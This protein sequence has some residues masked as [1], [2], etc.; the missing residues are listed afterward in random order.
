MNMIKEIQ[1]S[2]NRFEELVY[3]R[4]FLSNVSVGSPFF[5]VD[6][7]MLD[8]AALCARNGD[9]YIRPEISAMWMGW[10]LARKD[11][12]PN[13]ELGAESC[14]AFS[15]AERLTWLIH[16]NAYS[17]IDPSWAKPEEDPQ[18]VVRKRIDKHMI[19]RPAQPSNQD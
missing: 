19:R 13:E 15:D 2:R 7:D 18:Q 3:A 10:Q 11:R 4:Y 9:D 8:K 14:S 12:P 17:L 6:N 5:K 16:E 1:D